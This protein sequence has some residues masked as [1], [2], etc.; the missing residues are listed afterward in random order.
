MCRMWD[1][2]KGAL[3]AIRFSSVQCSR[4]VVSDSLRPHEL[5]H[6]RPPCPSPTPGVHSDSLQH[7]NL[8]ALSAVSPQTL[9]TLHVFK[10]LYRDRITMR[11]TARAA[12]IAQFYR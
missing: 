9:S 1:E 12:V 3:K 10:R 11:A 2:V 4:S 8:E 7:L 6:A 5:Q